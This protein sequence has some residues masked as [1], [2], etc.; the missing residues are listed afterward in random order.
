VLERQV[1]VVVEMM[2]AG[3]QRH[4]EVLAPEPDFLKPPCGPPSVFVQGVRLELFLAELQ[5]QPR[6]SQRL[7]LLPLLSEGHSLQRSVSLLP[8]PS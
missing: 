4:S 5:V 2:S 7:P 8:A 1:E 3:V 6:W